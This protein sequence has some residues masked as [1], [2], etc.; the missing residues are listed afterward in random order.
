R[1]RTGLLGDSF[2]SKFWRGWSV[3]DD[4]VAII[5][6]MRGRNGAPN[7]FGGPSDKRLLTNRGAADHFPVVCRLRVAEPSR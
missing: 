7:R 6:E 4:S 3:L 5:R 2:S 1:A